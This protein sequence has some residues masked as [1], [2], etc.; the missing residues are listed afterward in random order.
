[1]NGPQPWPASPC[2]WRNNTWMVRSRC[3]ATSGN[4]ERIR[5][6][7]LARVRTPR[8]NGTRCSG[9]PPQGGGKLEGAHG[10]P[11]DGARRAAR[12]AVLIDARPHAPP[13]NPRRVAGTRARSGSRDSPL[14]ALTI[15]AA[16]GD[17]AARR[18][19]LDGLK[20]RPDALLPPDVSVRLLG[21]RPGPEMYPVLHQVMLS[22][23]DESTRVE[24]IRLLGGY[25]PSRAPSSTS[26]AI[27][28]TSRPPFG[29]SG[30]G[31]TRT[32]AIPSAWPCTPYRLSRT[33]ELVTANGFTANS[34]YH[35]SNKENNQLGFSIVPAANSQV[36]REV[37]LE[38]GAQ[39][40]ER[41]V[42]PASVFPITKAVAALNHSVSARFMTR[43]RTAVLE[44]VEGETLSHSI[45]K[46]PL[47]LEE[48]RG[49][50]A[51]F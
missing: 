3:S 26:C 15:L 30:A 22:P 1:M 10:A 6:L 20:S 41:S 47:P 16:E 28:P 42:S 8:S 35:C 7:A 11:S 9:L 33:T 25:E 4:R 29:R 14:T 50:N 44:F 36:R 2:S 37:F 32:P 48:I 43:G 31:H 5:A 24:C 38:R 21:L 51:S 13:R 18:Q 27:A 46:G 12:N 45:K 23:P 49:N 39:L 34:R 40:A 19:L 17:D